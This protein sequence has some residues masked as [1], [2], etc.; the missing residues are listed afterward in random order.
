LGVGGGGQCDQYAVEVAASTAVTATNAW[1][2]PPAGRHNG[3]VLMPDLPTARTVPLGP[4]S[5]VDVRPQRG[6][7]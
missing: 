3:R 5:L 4:S 2:M 1:G 7:H 6:R